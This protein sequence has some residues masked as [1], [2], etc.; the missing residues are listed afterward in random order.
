MK[1]R[2]GKPPKAGLE[3]AEQNERRSGGQSSGKPGD[4]V[5]QAV[6][7]EKRGA[8]LFRRARQRQVEDSRFGSAPRRHFEKRAYP[9]RP[10][11]VF[12]S[13]HPA[14]RQQASGHGRAAGQDDLVAV[15]V[16][17]A[18]LLRGR[19]QRRQ[20]R[21]HTPAGDL[22]KTQLKTAGAAIKTDACQ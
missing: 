14:E 17:G 19:Q 4:A 2:P 1:A 20:G 18:S 21:G 13:E 15:A 9:D 12:G 16:S 11:A 8:T 7:S 5:S 10:E 3:P 22:R 6:H